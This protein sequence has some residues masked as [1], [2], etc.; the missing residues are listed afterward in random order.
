MV[1]CRAVF[2]RM[3]H[4]LGARILAPLF[5]VVSTHRR[6]RRRKE[7]SDLSVA[8]CE[9]LRRRR[10]NILRRQVPQASPLQLTCIASIE[11]LGSIFVRNVPTLT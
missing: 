8:H 9:W 10:V 4:W 6:N 11:K 3:K 1:D 2:K 5:S 7:E